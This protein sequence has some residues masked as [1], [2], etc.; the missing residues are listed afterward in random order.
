MTKWEYRFFGLEP[1]HQPHQIM[2]EF[3][4][5]GWEL[6]TIWRDTI[7]FQRPVEEKKE[8]SKQYYEC[9]GAD[10]SLPHP[11]TCA[12][13]STSTVDSPDIQPQRE[14]SRLR[15]LYK[16][17]VA[18]RDHALRRSEQAEAECG[19]LRGQLDG[20]VSAIDRLAKEELSTAAERDALH[21]KLSD[22]EA[23]IKAGIYGTPTLKQDATTYGDVITTL[24][25]CKRKK[26]IG[27]FVVDLPK[28]SQPK[29]WEGVRVFYNKRFR[30]DEWVTGRSKD[31]EM[32]RGGGRPIFVQGTAQT[33]EAHD[34]V[35]EL[36][37][38]E[39]TAWLDSH[40]LPEH[41][42]ATAARAAGDYEAL[43]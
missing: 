38:P 23:A 6:V 5:K 25:E 18:E 30:H 42:H 11:C 27:D 10:A 3:G 36:Q 39:R 1:S 7:Y 31:T 41:P 22:L 35:C 32:W 43:K 9:C 28:E 16:N 37:D 34:Y 20:A 4:D 14:N 29:K 15:Y 8:S 24:H 21:K 33:L 17:V 40:P 12:I 19:R 13:Q 2:Q 26:I